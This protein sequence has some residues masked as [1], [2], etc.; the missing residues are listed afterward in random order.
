MQMLNKTG[1]AMLCVLAGLSAAGCKRAQADD[2]APMLVHDGA[3]LEAPAGSPLRTHLVVQPVGGDAAARRLDVPA[4]VEADP[5]RVVNVVAPLTGRVIALNVAL[6]D[7]VQRGQVL[8][9]IASGD[10][11]QANSD[12]QKADDAFATADK[13]LTRA[14]GVQQAGGAATKD[15]EAAESAYNQAK[16][17]RERAHMRMEAL[18]GGGAHAA[19]QLVLT[20]P[21]DGVITT[22]AISRGA[23]VGDPTAVLMTV[24]NIER[25]YITANVPEDEVGLIAR[26]TPADIQL[27]A[28]PGQ[29][30]HGAVS[31]VNAV[32]EPD[33]HRQKVRIALDNP[34][35]RLMPNMY[36]TAAFTPPASSGASGAVSAPQSALLM[37]NDSITVMVEVRPWVF[38][39]REV[40]LGD[41]TDAAARVLSG[42]A[43][44]DRIVIRGGVLLND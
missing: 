26:G 37:N 5:A 15:I 4:V 20:A 42:L 40:K 3:L 7:H 22:L 2:A 36:A 35:G 25:V 44:G 34:G 28:Y 31:E 30:L 39:R 11:A 9:V 29:T 16:S 21:R 33:T 38:E 1:V 43:P 13:A 23:Q 14:R 27:T 6:G 41:E 10:L 18:N 32:I 24:T 17:E 8:A 12:L 19:G